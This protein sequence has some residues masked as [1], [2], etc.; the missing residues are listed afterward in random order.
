MDER[1]FFTKKFFKLN[2]MIMDVVD[3]FSMVNFIQLNIEDEDSV[4]ELQMNID[5]IIQY[6]EN[7]M[8][9]DKHFL[10]NQGDDK[11][12]PDTLEAAAA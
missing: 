6:D 9:N 10:D 3:N 2:N 7:R 12:E 8:P 1:N 5:N 11:D 4:Q